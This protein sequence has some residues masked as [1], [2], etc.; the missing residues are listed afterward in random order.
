MTEIN[1]QQ[2]RICANK[3]C[4]TRFIGGRSDKSI[5]VV[6]VGAQTFNIGIR[7]Q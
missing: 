2:V 1:N 3:F 6:N 4:E 7:T 5:A